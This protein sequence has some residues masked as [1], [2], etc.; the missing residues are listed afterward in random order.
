MRQRLQQLIHQLPPGVREPLW[1]LLFRVRWG[2]RPPPTW[3]DL[4]GYELLLAEMER[5]GVLSVDG[6]VVEIGVFLGGGTYKLARFLEERAPSKRVYAID[7]FDPDFDATP[8][9]GGFTMADF[10]DKLLRGR[11]QRAVYDDV[12]RGLANLTTIEGDSRTVDIPARKVCFAYIDGNHEPEYVRSDFERV[13]ERTS[14]GG[15]VA[16]DDYGDDLPE[17]TRA[18]NE[19]VGAHSAEIAR[20]WT[21]GLKAFFVQRAAAPR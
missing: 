4:T 8:S 6:D 5:A 7:I 9:T 12:T 11:S 10:Y 20:V 1:S 14:P 19:L 21:A 17:V 15:V 16:F 18:V 3:S 13:W 2:F